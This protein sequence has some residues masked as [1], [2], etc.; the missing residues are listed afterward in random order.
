MRTSKRLSL[1]ICLVFVIALAIVPM[2]TLTSFA[3]DTKEVTFE[4]GANGSASH[5][6]G[7]SKTTYSETV[8]GYTLSLTNGTQFYTGGRDAKG[9]SCIKLGTSKV[10]GTFTFTV[11]ENVTSVVIM[12]ARYKNYDNSKITVNGGDEITLETN[13]NDGQYYELVIDTTTTKTVTISTVAGNLRVMID[14]IT[15]VCGQ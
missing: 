3:E 8:D 11:G 6:D 9:N 2:L 15:L 13:S 4:L 7:S 12:V 10:E 5:A 1:V 14:S